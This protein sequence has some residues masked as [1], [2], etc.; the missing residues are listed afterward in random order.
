MFN[1]QFNDVWLWM[2]NVSIIYPCKLIYLE[3]SLDPH[4][5]ECKTSNKLIWVFWKIRN[6]LFQ[7]CIRRPTF[8]F[9][10]RKLSALFCCRGRIEIKYLFSWLLQNNLLSVEMLF[11]IQ[12]PRLTPRLFLFQKF[13]YLG[14]Y[15]ATKRITRALK[16]KKKRNSGLKRKYKSVHSVELF[17]HR[18]EN[19]LCKSL[20]YG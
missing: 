13:L 8:F 18:K 3:R 9:Y 20:N 17:S 16:K 14:G 1:P 11:E 4:F 15:S 6:C 5:A 7:F 19:L 12:K 10:R 2:R